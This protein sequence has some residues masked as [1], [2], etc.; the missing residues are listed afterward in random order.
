M[1]SQFLDC[2]LGLFQIGSLARSSSSSLYNLLVYLTSYDVH[3]PVLFKAS[4]TPLVRASPSLNLL[5]NPVS[6]IRRPLRPNLCRRQLARYLLHPDEFLDLHNH[7][8]EHGVYRV[9][10]C[11]ASLVQTQSCQHGASTVWHAN[12]GAVERDLEVGRWRG[13]FARGDGS[14]GGRRSCHFCGGGGC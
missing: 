13:G 12:G 14:F 1:A 5:L 11:L 2:S 9:I 6:R 3:S 8:R 4:Q 10:Y 7:T